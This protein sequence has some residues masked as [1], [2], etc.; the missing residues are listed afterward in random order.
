MKW[1]LSLILIFSVAAFGKDENTIKYPEARKSDQ[2]DDY[3]G[4]KVAGPYRWL[5]D[6]DLPESRAWIEAENKVTFDYLSKI[7]ARE[8]IKKRI[9][10]L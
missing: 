5:E 4:T 2:V 10:E 7:P 6:P 1:P 9:T 3:H 8:T